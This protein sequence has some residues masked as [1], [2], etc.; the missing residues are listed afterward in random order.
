MH[1]VFTKQ[2]NYTSG[3]EG[4]LLLVKDEGFLERAEI[5]SEKAKTEASFSAVR[6]TSTLRLT[7]GVAIFLVNF[8]LPTYG[9]SFSK[10][11]R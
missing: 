2:K 3:G 7:Q 6:L 10:P 8:K 11:M 1:S 5:I 9:P 4:E